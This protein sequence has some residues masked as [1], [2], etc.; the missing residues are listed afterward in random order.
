M[1]TPPHCK[2]FILSGCL[3][4]AWAFTLSMKAAEVTMPDK[5]VSILEQNCLRC[6]NPNIAK[7]ELALDTLANA[8]HGGKKGTAL[9]PGSPKESSLLERVLSG[10]MPEDA[11]PLPPEQAE[12]LKKWIEEGAAWPEKV[13]LREPAA[14]DKSWWAYQPLKESVPQ[15]HP[16][17]PAAWQKSA[18]DR[19][20]YEGLAEAGLEPNP[21]VD[22]R[23]LIR[24]V[25]Y[26]LIGLPP[27]PE[28]VDAFVND[29][30]PKAWERLVDRL[31]A[32][33]H[34]G[35]RWGRHWLDVVRFGESKGFERNVIV[36]NIWP[37]R[38]YVIDSINADK[39][40]NQFIIEHLAGD[41]VGKGDPE[42]EVG[43]AFLVAGPY[44]DVGNQD[45][46][47]KKIIRA[48][49]LDDT[50]TATGSAFLGLTVNCAKCHDHKFDPIAQED[51]YHLRAAF[52]GVEQGERVLAAPEEV[53]AYKAATDP[54]KAEEAALKAEIA[55]IEK[56]IVD[57]AAQDEARYLTKVTRPK[58]DRTGTVDEFAPV[59]AKIVR[60]T[61]LT[62]DLD[63]NSRSFRMDEFEVWTA[64]DEPRNVALAS[65][66]GVAEAEVVGRAVEDTAENADNAYGAKLVND[67]KFGK[68]WFGSKSLTLHLAK[69]ERINKVVFSSDRPAELPTH[70]KMVFVG[71][72]ILEVSEDGK[73]WTQVAQSWDRKPINDRFLK[74]RY[75]RF[76]TSDEERAQLAEL[77][78]QVDIVGGKLRKIA[79]LERVWAGK[80]VQPK[81]AT[82]LAIGG[83]PNKPAE[84]VV[85]ASLSTLEERVPSYQLAGDASEATRRYELAK[86][87]VHED[88][89]LTPRVL[90]N[91]VWHYHFGTGIVNTPSDF[92]YMGGKP[93]HP[94]LLDYLALRL[95]AYG[96]RWKPLHR[97]ILLSQAYQQ[98]ATYRDSAAAVD[99]DSRLLWRFPPRRLSA[100]EIRDTMLM[101]AG[102]LDTTMGGP[103][104]R[105]YQFT[106]DNVCTYHPLDEHGPETWR[107]A[108]YH[109]NP[110]AAKMDLLTEFDCPD[111]AFATPRRAS[112]ITP[113]QA[114]TLMN[115]S[116][117]V[118]MA[119]YFAE[120]LKAESSDPARQVR[121]GFEI[122][123]GRTPT[124]VESAAAQDLLSQHGLLAFARALFNSNELIFLN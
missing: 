99:S 11:D 65:N 97:E 49:T 36:N 106:Q 112:T 37:F 95:K 77:R 100:E 18:I 94:K 31:L 2:R 111:P 98:A 4:L 123:Y 75:L 47:Q 8:Q 72:Y 110:R 40:F 38:D 33:P 101:V 81:E 118:D 64:E 34:Y 26:D 86:W 73:T 25:T 46:K 41:V 42:I 63:P 61:A 68:R 22:R 115:H 91:R 29:P 27:T 117:T 24:R 102:K 109:Q 124:P 89:P 62:N 88:N 9:V 55:K 113:L 54:L 56:A 13:V 57:R 121:R 78:K 1:K 7:G 23:D 39:P 14:A 79:P 84:A 85:P 30:D 76:A 60:L 107:R 96:W 52:E 44:D 59:K 116:F 45:P 58:V 71:E 90:A 5:V 51:Y 93:S 80:F 87:L 19:F 32:S 10:D 108:V 28:E 120:R 15:A 114:L 119:G 43:T 74:E 48:N 17:A 16:N 35:E 50:I 92:G 66:G 83:D 69:P 122:A 6:H 53:A 20:I 105:L 104:F 67:G 12:V 21:P 70:G 3:V 82:F 103:G